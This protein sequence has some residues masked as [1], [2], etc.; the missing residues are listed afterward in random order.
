MFPPTCAP[1][2]IRRPH[3]CSASTPPLPAPP[4][5]PPARPRCPSPHPQGG[6][7]L[8]SGCWTA[9]IVRLS[10]PPAR[11]M[12][13]TS[14]SPRPAHAS[15]TTLVSRPASPARAAASPSCCCAPAHGSRA[16]A[17]R[18]AAQRIARSSPSPAPNAGGMPSARAALDRDNVLLVR[19]G[20]FPVQ[21]VA[22]LAVES[23]PGQS[24]SLDVTQ[25]EL[26]TNGR[27]IEAPLFAALATAPGQPLP[28][29]GAGLWRARRAWVTLTYT[30]GI[31]IGAVPYDVQQ[32]CI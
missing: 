31:S 9:L 11:R 30:G 27:L 20:H 26:P 2:P 3:P 7:P 6:L 15:P 4:P 18:A 21:S 28:L 5:R 23:L 8:P 10:K 29:A 19:P 16:T 22:A 1:P 12:A 24:F 13:R 14:H 17:A 25:L 32:A